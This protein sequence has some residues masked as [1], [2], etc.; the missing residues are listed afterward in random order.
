[1]P[2]GETVLLLTPLPVLT[3][4]T[5]LDL[6]AAAAAASAT[7][8]LVRENAMRKLAGAVVSL[9]KVSATEW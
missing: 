1:V 9:L 5:A 4:T 2:A 3:N 6:P 8:P 7:S